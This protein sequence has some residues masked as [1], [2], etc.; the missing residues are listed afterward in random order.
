MLKIFLANKNTRRSNMDMYHTLEIHTQDIQLKDVKE[1]NIIAVIQHLKA[2]PTL[3]E[4][5]GSVRLNHIGKRSAFV[6]MLFVEIQHRRQQIG[7]LLM[8]HCINRAKE[9]GCN[10]ITLLV[11]KEAHH[12][13]NFYT[14]CGFEFAYEYCD[15]MD[16]WVKQL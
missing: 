4:I 15:E 11:D 6:H 8:K 10:T 2:L 9:S 16:L 13:H 5:V 14:H 1:T 12:I 3:T 7:S